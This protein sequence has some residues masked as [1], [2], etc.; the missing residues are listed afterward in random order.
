MASHKELINA[1]K[2]DE[3]FK[4]ALLDYYSYGF[5]NLGFFEKTKHATLSEDWLRLNSVIAD[6]LEWSEDRKRIMFASADSE[7]MDENPFH[8]I[9]RFCRY[10]PLTY[11]AYFLHTVAVLSDAFTLRENL[12]DMGLSDDLRARLKAVLG[13]REDVKTGDFLFFLD[14]ILYAQ[15]HDNAVKTLNKRL[16]EFAE[17]GIL[18]RI[19]RTGKKGGSGD[20]RWSLPPLTVS[21]ILKA[22]RKVN[23]D[24]EHHLHSALD[25][26]SKYHLFGEV[27]TF[28]QDRLYSDRVSPFRFKHEYFMQSLNDFNILDLVYAIEGNKWCKI[29]CRH[30]ITGYETELLC[31]PLEIRISNMNGREFLMYYEP[32]KGC[33]TSLRIEFIDSIVYYDD[34]KV[35]A[36][37]AQTGY[38]S[39]S[40]AVDEA[41]SNARKSLKYTWGVA[42]SKD[43]EGS[44]V[45]TVPHHPVTFE[46]TYHPEQEYYI[47]SRLYRERRFG[48][49]QRSEDGFRLRFRAEVSDETELRP[50]LRSFY[51]R[52]LSCEGM[53]A[54]DFSLDGDVERIVDH[55]SRE[56][57]A[58]PIRKPPRGLRSKWEIPQ[59][60][61]QV[62]G[63]GTKARAHDL[64]FHEIYGIYYYIIADVVTRLSAGNRAYS[65]LEV[66]QV[67]E[68]SL[69]RFR[70]LTGQSTNMILP[71]EIKELLLDGRFLRTVKQPVEGVY[72]T[73]PNKAGTGYTKRLKTEEV[74]VPTYVCAPGTQLYRDVL[75]LTA[76]EIRWLKTVL[77]HPKMNLFFSGD[78]IGLLKRLLKENAP[79][80]KPLPMNKVVY[81]DR[82]RFAEKNTD[83]EA[84]VLGIIL[85]GI[86]DRRTVRL[87][88]R[89]RRG[90]YKSGE[91]RPILLEFSKRNNRFQGFFQSC[92]SD[93]ILTFNIAQIMKATETGNTFDYAAAEQTYLA[94]RQN[95]M[96]S[97]EVEFRNGRNVAERILT[98]LSPWKKRCTYDP[99]TRLFRLT[100]FYQAEDELDLVVRFLGYGA[101]IRFTHRE[102]P[103]FRDYQSRM[104]RQ[105]KLNRE[106][107][108]G[109]RE[110][111]TGD[112]R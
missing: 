106:R 56:E 71:K 29:K 45:D 4:R 28:L 31:Y 10:N 41:I 1:G 6:Y 86:Y 43:R 102:H 36:I 81:Y 95:H 50:W 111:E 79:E 85:K 26:F 98:E 55:I 42:T 75:P 83:R 12:D 57:F 87:K 14:G 48:S 65:K 90:G 34:A 84:A 89:T 112:G 59:Q 93:R 25:Y 88:Y 73:V 63:D 51:G 97:V 60:V 21:R 101:N 32:F 33:Y 64:L 16:D 7:A 53:E 39:S 44:A 54:E 77:S 23:E 62:L 105:L 46:L 2:F 82:F 37:L 61:K 15:Q 19:Q 52:I 78:E 9:Y 27:G 20:R 40:E 49:V 99:E 68:E 22:G 94:Y 80:A 18:H 3:K 5:K 17:F 103:I 67:I 35:K 92:K 100:V 110:Q 66:G 107:T 8:R 11:P 70:P 91:Y 47:A 69:L 108:S 76:L 72:E 38:H 13:K 30:G 96:R 109:G 58:A 24:F 74:Y 104:N